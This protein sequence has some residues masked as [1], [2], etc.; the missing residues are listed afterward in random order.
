MKTLIESPKTKTYDHDELYE[1]TSSFCVNKPKIVFSIYK[2]DGDM[3]IAPDIESSEPV[4]EGNVQFMIDYWR[5]SDYPIYSPVISSPT[6]RDIINACNDL[7]I[8]G[9]GC[10][11]FLEAL[12]LVKDEH[13]VKTV[14][15]SIGS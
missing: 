10:G 7:L 15:F 8:Q 6:W 11:I 3:L 2:G 14:R 13:D 9:D 4:I 12:Y 5:V 1:I